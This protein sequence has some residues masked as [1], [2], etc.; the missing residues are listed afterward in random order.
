MFLRK[1][2]KGFVSSSVGIAVFL[3]ASQAGAT[4]VDFEDA[5]TANIRA[6]QSL[7]SQGFKLTQG[8]STSAFAMVMGNAGQG[9][10]DFSG[11]QTNRLVAFNDT[12]LTFTS[13]SNAAFDLL[14]FDGGESW[15]MQPHRWARQISVTGTTLSG[16]TVNQ[17]FDLDLIKS[18]TAGMQTFTLN[19]SFR[20]LSSAVFAGIGGNPEFS[21]DNIS[22]SAP[23]VSDVPEPGTFILLGLGLMGIGAMRRKAG[24]KAG[25]K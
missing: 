15:I 16:V 17:M 18:A 7:V 25:S 1:H 20:N 6:G 21:L 19:D 23:M 10:T 2:L 4:I 13:A 8:V 22:V 14:A 9:W 24:S 12:T 3:A 11:N 5:G